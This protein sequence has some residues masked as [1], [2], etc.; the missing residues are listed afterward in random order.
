MTANNP[1]NNTAGAL[2]ATSI[3][4]GGSTLNTYSQ[5]TSWTPVFTFATPG[6]LSVVYAVQFG[7]YSR[8]GNIIHAIFNLSVTPTFTTASGAVNITG[9][10]FANN[11]ASNNIA[12]GTLRTNG[13]A[14]PA[15]TTSLVTEIQPGASLLTINAC[16]S[17]TGDTAFSTTQF[18]SGV[19]NSCIGAITYLI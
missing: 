2:S 6:N 14:W 12:I 5:F 17:A 15:G 18:A 7:V 13:V 1:I 19:A 8:I 4:F 9:L 10:P 11:S 16:G 3:S